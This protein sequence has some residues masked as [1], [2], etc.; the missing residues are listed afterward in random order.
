MRYTIKAA[1]GRNV[2]D[3]TVHGNHVDL[4]RATKELESKGAAIIHTCEDRVTMDN[5]PQQ[6]RLLD[7]TFGIGK[8]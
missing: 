7:R 8:R 4:T 6:R 2:T 1:K 3:Y 5:K